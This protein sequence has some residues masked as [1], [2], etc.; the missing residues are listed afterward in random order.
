MSQVT[1]GPKGRWSSDIGRATYLASSDWVSFHV[2]LVCSPAWPHSQAKSQVVTRRPQSCLCHGA[3]APS[4]PWGVLSA[5]VRST[6]ESRGGV[7]ASGGPSLI[8]PLRPLLR[9]AWPPCSTSPHSYSQWVPA[10]PNR[11][12]WGAPRG[13]AP[14]EWSPQGQVCCPPENKGVHMDLLCRCHAA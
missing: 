12:G 13:Q 3:H 11:A 7:G 6:R 1:E 4:A 9:L 8:L 10:L 5:S 14:R 2:R